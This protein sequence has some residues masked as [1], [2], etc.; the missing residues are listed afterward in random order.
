MSTKNKP[1]R[2]ALMVK[3]RLANSVFRDYEKQTGFDKDGSEQVGTK[4][5]AKKFQDGI[6]TDLYQDGIG[7]SVIKDYE[8]QTDCNQDGI[9]TN[10]DQAETEDAKHED[11]LIQAENEGAEYEDGTKQTV[12]LRAETGGAKNYEAGTKKTDHLQAQT[13]GG[14]YQA[15]TEGGKN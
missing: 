12:T 14:E 2:G 15:G 7:N 11:D 3:T 6:G 8:T 1:L 9:E 10:L 13:E 4:Q 5:G